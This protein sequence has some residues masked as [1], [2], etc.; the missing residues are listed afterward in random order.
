MFDCPN[1]MN[2]SLPSNGGVPPA[3]L[4]SV[5]AADSV[6]WLFSLGAA[7]EDDAS[8][9]VVEGWGTSLVVPR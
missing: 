9:G 7:S 4:S 6:A 8:L 3:V 2:S 5:R 1:K